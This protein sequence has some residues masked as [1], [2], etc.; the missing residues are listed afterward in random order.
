MVLKKII[1]IITSIIFTVISFVT[2][3]F[4]IEN[5]GLNTPFNKEDKEV[6]NSNKSVSNS[7]YMQLVN[8]ENLLSENY[9]PKNLVVTSLEATNYVD[10]MQLEQSTEGAAKEMFTKAIEDGIYLIAISGYRD[11]SE[12]KHLFQSRVNEDGLEETLKDT[13]IPGSSEHQTGL[14]L[15]ILGEDYQYLDE[16]FANSESYKWLINN[17]YKYGFI[18][19]YPKGKEDITGVHFEPWQYRYI[20]DKEIA[21]EIMKSNSTLEEYLLNLQ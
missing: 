6:I 13:A 4:V 8:K 3:Y 7:F 19:R 2:I 12:Q 16:G 9:I 18:L 15:D 5:R 11:Y 21:E 10:N 20:G 17:C 1:L 14:A